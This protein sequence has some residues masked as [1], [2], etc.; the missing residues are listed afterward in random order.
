LIQR[1]IV[2]RRRPPEWAKSAK[3]PLLSYSSGNTPMRRL[4]RSGLHPQ[5]AIK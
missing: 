4:V 2:C 3:F 5:P 1:A